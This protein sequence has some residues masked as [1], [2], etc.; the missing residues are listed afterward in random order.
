[1][2]LDGEATP[3]PYSPLPVWEPRQADG[4][5]RGFL[6]RAGYQRCHCTPVKVCRSSRSFQMPPGGCA[7]LS[8]C[9]ARSKVDADTV[10]TQWFFVNSL[11]GF[12]LLNLVV[13]PAG[14]EPTTP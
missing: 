9:P 6:M 14:F 7:R 10:Q 12:N 2:S 13:S 1:M 11:L 5:R 4:N 8:R 3:Q